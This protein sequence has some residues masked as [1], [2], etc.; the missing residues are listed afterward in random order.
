VKTPTHVRVCPDIEGL[1]IEAAPPEFELSLLYVAV[2]LLYVTLT[3]DDGSVST[4]SS[5]TAEDG[6]PFVMFSL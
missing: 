6:P 2:L 5:I 1:D 4:K 3:G